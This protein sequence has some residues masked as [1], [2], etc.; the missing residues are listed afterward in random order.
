MPAGVEVADVE[1]TVEARC[2]NLNNFALIFSW[3]LCG[4]R[5]LQ[6]SVLLFLLSRLILAIVVSPVW[7]LLGARGRCS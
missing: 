6:Q 7:F 1:V 5:V 4:E 2:L 3:L